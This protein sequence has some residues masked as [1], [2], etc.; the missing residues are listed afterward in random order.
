[1][2]RVLVAVLVLALAGCAET[3]T[4]QERPAPTAEAEQAA[5]S[6]PADESGRTFQGDAYFGTLPGKHAVF[7][8][9]DGGERGEAVDRVIDQ[10]FV[11]QSDAY[12]AGDLPGRISGVQLVY[13]RGSVLV[14]ERGAGVRIRFTVAG[15]DPMSATSVGPLDFRGYG[16]SRRVGQWPVVQ[17]VPLVDALGPALASCSRG[18]GEV[19]LMGFCDSGGKGSTGCGTS[20]PGGGSCSV[21]CGAGYFSCCQ[22]QSCSCT[23]VNSVAPDPGV[24]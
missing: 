7:I 3:P 12:P 20:C 11:L 15:K 23:C 2:S 10:V 21:S 18:P 14:R 6:T 13:T 5:L 4:R 1:M 16:L 17:G 22:A 19:K 24:G 8:A 9:F